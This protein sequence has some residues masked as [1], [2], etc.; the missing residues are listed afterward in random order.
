MSKDSF[1]IHLESN[2]K[3]SSTKKN[4]PEKLVSTAGNCIPPSGIR[5]FFDIVSSMP[6]CISLGVGEPDFTTPWR[7]SDSGIYALKD[8]HT[9]YT[10]NKG[11][12]ELREV[13][14]E[15]LESHFNISYNPETELLVSMGVSQG[16]DLALRSI[17]NPGDEVIIF[18]PC[19]VSYAPNISMLHGI[20]VPI[21]TFSKDGFN[22]DMDRLKKAVTPKTKAILLNYP[23]NPTGA[24]LNKKA[25]QKVAQVAIENNLIVLSD[26]IYSAITYEKDHF[27]ITSLPGMKERTIYLNG[28]S[29]SHAMTGWRLGFVGGPEYLVNTMFKI[30]QYTALCASSIAQYAAIEA[31]SNGDKD[32]SRMKAEYFKRRNFMTSSFN[33]AG[34]PCLLPGGAFY[35]FPD[36]TPT[37][38]SS[39]DFALQLL[40]KKKVAVVP[41]SVFGS[42]GEGH[43]RCSFATSMENL[44]ESMKRIAEFAGEN[45]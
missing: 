34:L 26:E 9:H 14:S 10:S 21:P 32:V 2:L 20:P 15:Y 1:I 40:D 43:I 18:E 45:S 8:G 33:D 28:F 4:N 13:I 22:M 36:I 7:I 37:G 30:H 29:K 42:A 27:S 3:Q 12:P 23:A 31:I 6:D 11:M 38:L 41:G 24:T 5:E 25:L 44:K 19:Y 16:L 17:V 35:V 39:R